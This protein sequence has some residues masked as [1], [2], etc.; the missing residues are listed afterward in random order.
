MN[1]HI[2]LTIMAVIAPIVFIT[3]IIEFIPNARIN[4]SVKETSRGILLICAFL[5]GF[6]FI[7]YARD[8]QQLTSKPKTETSAKIDK[9]SMLTKA[10]STYQTS[11]ANEKLTKINVNANS[12]VLPDN[13]THVVYVNNAGKIVSGDKSETA[14]AMNS[15]HDFYVFSKEK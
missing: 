6:F 5:A 10:V 11:H 7:F 3:A 2:A 9:T 4:Q 14:N 12:V 8:L 1:F 13:A 15:K